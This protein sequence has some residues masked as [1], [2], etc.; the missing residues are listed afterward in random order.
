MRKKILKIF[1][2]VTA[3]A[4]C[5]TSYSQITLAFDNNATESDK[6]KIIVEVILNNKDEKSIENIQFD[7]GSYLK[8]YDYEIKYI[9]KLT[10]DPSYLSNY[11]NQVLWITRDGVISLSLDPVDKVRKSKKEKDTA[12]NI[13]SGK[14]TGVAYSKYWPT[15][16]QK[17]KTFKWQYDCHFYFAKDKEEWNLEPSREANN[18][19]E[20]V[21]SKC[22][23]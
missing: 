21:S 16:S 2:I 23:P 11:F 18:Y 12:W 14:T 3:I 15:D 13:L 8:D 4:I 10:R 6:D 1:S 17:E 7:D 20:V 19:L 9:Y 22:N 5:L